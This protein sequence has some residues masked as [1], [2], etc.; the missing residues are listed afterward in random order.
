MKAR[1][2]LEPGECEIE[3]IEMSEAEHRLLV[4]LVGKLSWNDLKD[5][6]FNDDE[7]RTILNWLLGV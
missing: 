6:G 3:C 2:K 4:R 7:K 1:W 5:R